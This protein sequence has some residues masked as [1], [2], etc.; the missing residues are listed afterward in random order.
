[1]RDPQVVGSGRPSRLNF[2]RLAARANNG[3][4]KRSEVGRFVAENL[5]KDPNSG[6]FGIKVAT[7]FDG[8]LFAFVAT[9][10][11]ALMGTVFGSTEDASRA[12]REFEAKFTKLTSDDNLFGSSGEFGLLF[13]LLANKP[14]ANKIGGEPTV[15]VRD[16]EVMFVERRLP[17]GVENWKKLRADWVV[18]TIGLAVSAA[19]EFLVLRQ[20]QLRANP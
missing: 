17:E 20:A 18:N 6:V 4:I 11:P 13:S 3:V 16:L 5:V 9:I 15:T 10:G 8:D 19:K 14:G 7:L 1:M 12:H 2:D